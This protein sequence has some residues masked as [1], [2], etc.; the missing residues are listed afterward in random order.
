[1]QWGA[2]HDDDRRYAVPAPTLLPGPAVSR[3]RRVGASNWREQWR[4]A[5]S[6]FGTLNAD[7]PKRRFGR[8]ALLSGQC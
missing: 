7:L 3:A 4:T 8:S 5:I 1:M 2:R 6:G